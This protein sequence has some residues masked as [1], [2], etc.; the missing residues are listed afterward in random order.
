MTLSGPEGTRATSG[1]RTALIGASLTAMAAVYATIVPHEEAFLRS[2]FGDA[3]DRYC[4]LVPRLFPRVV[5]LADGE[6]TWKPDAIAGERTTLALF[7][8]MMLVLILKCRRGD[9]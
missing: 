7:G 6:G 3:F 4:E 8:A 2:R 9:D 5:P 1:H